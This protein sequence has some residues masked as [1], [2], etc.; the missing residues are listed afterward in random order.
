MHA[1]RALV[2]IGTNSTRFLVVGRDVADAVTRIAQESR[3]TR[4]GVGLR[5]GGF[6]DPDA[7]ART[8][9]AIETYMVAIR[10][11][12]A[13]EI[14]CV[15][16]SALRR[17]DDAASFAR[18]AEALV[19]APL[20]VLSGDEEARYAFAGATYTA[21]G[22]CG[23]VG[24]LDVGGGS[25][26]YAAGIPGTPQAPDIVRSVE[27]GA[28]RLGE[29]V[30]ALLGARALDA[31]ERAIVLTQARNIAGEA[32][33]PLR[34]VPI[35]E[36]LVAVGG[37]VMTIAVMLAD[38][39]TQAVIDGATRMRLLDDLL[40]C[41]LA[42]RRAIPRMRHQRADILAAG[43]VVVDE[44]IRALRCDAVATSLDDVLLGVCID[45]ASRFSAI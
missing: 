42:G 37:T 18:E 31:H 4:L 17:A 43:I 11:C 27:I 10:A 1:R 33:A 32:L 28:V 23:T 44:A 26:E 5:E 16:T 36:R 22:A 3:G 34:S 35:P 13:T 8:L 25:S 12:D 30:P 40:A 41:D 14:A 19:G 24:V 39:P 21:R 15:A 6:L 29:A 38:D 9:A 2:S 20:R 45:P 7:R